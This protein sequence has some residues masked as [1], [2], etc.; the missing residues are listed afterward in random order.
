MRLRVCQRLVAELNVHPEALLVNA[1]LLRQGLLAL[2]LLVSLEHRLD[3][4]EE[5]QREL[6]VLDG[7]E[8]LRQPAFALAL[9]LP[10]LG[11]LE[12]AVEGPVRVLLVHVREVEA[13]PVVPGRDVKRP[14]ERNFGF[15]HVVGLVVVPR[16]VERHTGVHAKEEPLLCLFVVS[17]GGNVV[18]LGH[19]DV[20][21]VDPDVGGCEHVLVGVGVRVFRAVV[22]GVV[23]AAEA[24]QALRDHLERSLGLVN[25]ALLSEQ[26]AQTVRRVQ[27]A[28]AL[29]QGLGVV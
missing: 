27:V 26:D 20:S 4:L 14:L 11:S 3:L 21:L 22:L 2:L 23:S 9:L 25:L 15:L 28:A 6:E 13:K 8:H 12:G 1:N 18:P 7:V 19:L 17:R 16:L 10:L 24:H 29:L 5:L